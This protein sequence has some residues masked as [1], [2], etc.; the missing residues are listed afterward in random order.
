MRNFKKYI[1]VIIMLLVPL[2]ATSQ[3]VPRDPLSIEAM[4]N[5]HRVVRTALDVRCLAEIMLL[6]K[7]KE[8]AGQVERYDSISK[9][10]DRYQRD[11][12]LLRTIL[13]G[14]GL[15]YK[16]IASCNTITNDL[17][18]Y[19]DLLQD[20]TDL[21][22]SQRRI[23]K[24]D[25]VILNE[26]KK[27]YSQIKDIYPELK[28]S[29]VNLAGQLTG[30]TQCKTSQLMLTMDEVNDNLDKLVSIIDSSY[31]HLWAY[32]TMR[33]Y[34]FNKNMFLRPSVQELID[35]AYTSWMRS[36]ILVGNS[37]KS[38]HPIDFKVQLG[39]GSLLGQPRTLTKTTDI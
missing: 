34:Y 24:T 1:F 33:K 5:N 8:T 25:T 17:A 2:A 31:G 20:Y 28:K 9:G 22:Y 29:L 37:I 3:G 30:V 7:H 4:I 32:M 21:V 13:Q 11:F 10:I 15:T 16:I 14:A 18:N 19:V 39:G 35:G 27:M 38:R 12:N 36:A 26:S 23:E 6:E